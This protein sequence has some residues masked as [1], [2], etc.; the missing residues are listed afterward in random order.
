M[1]VLLSALMFGLLCS[2][3]AAAGN[4]DADKIRDEIKKLKAE[5]KEVVKQV[6]DRYDRLIKQDRL[7]EE[8]LSEERRSIA[9]EEESL[10]ATAKTSTEREKIRDHY[11]KLRD[12][13]QKD[14]KLDSELI[15]KLRDTEK[16]SEKQ[17]HTAY[18]ARIDQL[19]DM[20]KASKDKKK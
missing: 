19:E 16:D 11:N 4:P 15:Q 7:S 20:L 1:R 6:H 9:K 12:L 3:A 5:E 18:K 10:L 14:I 13:L 2:V 17:V 8:T